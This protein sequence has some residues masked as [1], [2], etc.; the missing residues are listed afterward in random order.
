M[1]DVPVEMS[2]QRVAEVAAKLTAWADTL[3]AEDQQVLKAIMT[4]GAEAWEASHSD[5]SGFGYR[6][7]IRSGGS[8]QLARPGNS[9][10]GQFSFGFNPFNLVASGG[11]N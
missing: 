10:G 11:G 5:V 7:A 8:P 2:E 4:A 3:S 9:F 1:A 6:P